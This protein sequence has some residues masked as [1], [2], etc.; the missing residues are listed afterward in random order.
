MGHWSPKPLYCYFWIGFKNDT[1]LITD[2]WTTR[3]IFIFLI[4]C[5]VEP[6]PPFFPIFLFFYGRYLTLEIIK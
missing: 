5:T 2:N 1:E 4:S 3:S 6:H